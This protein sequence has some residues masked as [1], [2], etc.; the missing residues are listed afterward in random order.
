METLMDFIL[1]GAT[2][3]T[4]DVLIRIFIFLCFLEC[5]SGIC[6]TFA[7]VGRR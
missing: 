5:I 4:P 3:F 6:Q 2:E 1:S 7:S